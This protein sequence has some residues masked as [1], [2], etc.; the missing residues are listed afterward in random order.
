MKK[1]GVITGATSGIGKSYAYAL[2]KQG[3]DL[4]LTG[5]R[6]EHLCQTAKVLYKTYGT[7]VKICLLDFKNDKAFNRF[8]QWLNDQGSIHLLVNNA[9]YGLEES[10]I[11]DTYSNQSDMLKVHVQRTL[12]LSHLIGNKMKKAHYGTIINVCSL[13]A[14]IPLPTSALYAST[15]AFLVTFSECLNLE[16]SQYGVRVQ[17]LCPGFVHTDFHN[18]LSLSKGMVKAMAQLPFMTSDA[19]V[20]D[21]LTTLQHNTHVI[22][23]PGLFNRLGYLILK[24]MPKRLYYAIALKK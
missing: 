10:F 18:K 22:V 24:Y 9:G 12:E 1:V 7:N 15:K 14:F 3:Y 17:A 23:V 5:R 6:E 16:L 19:V 2:A 4:I 8:L 21:S 20:S 11:K 13:A